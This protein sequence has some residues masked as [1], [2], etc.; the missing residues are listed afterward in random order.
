MALSDSL[1]KFSRSHHSFCW[2][3]HKW[4]KKYS[5]ICYKMRI[6][7][8][9]KSLECTV[10]N[11]LE[12]LGE[13]YCNM[14]HCTVCL[15]QLSFFYFLTSSNHASPALHD[16]SDVVSGDDVLYNN[17]MSEEIQK[18]LILT[19]KSADIWFTASVTQKF[20]C[21]QSVTTMCLCMTV[22]DAVA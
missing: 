22:T 21:C 18:T 19:M 20:C 4:P 7:N 17:I 6:G 9:T 5:H 11:D 13:I 10:S 14:K 2:M 12:W 3:S 15:R 8:C 16:A 1:T